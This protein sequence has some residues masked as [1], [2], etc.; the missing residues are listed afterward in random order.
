V[1]TQTR[2]NRT[3]VLVYRLERG[4]VDRTTPAQIGIGD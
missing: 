4:R 2:D 3:H 1:F